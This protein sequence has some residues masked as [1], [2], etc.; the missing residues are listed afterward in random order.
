MY[1]EL[2]ALFL[3][4]M[5]YFSCSPL[6]YLLVYIS[7]LLLYWV[8]K[9]SLLRLCKAPPI[10]SHSIHN[11]AMQ[12]ILVGLMM[13]SIV[14]PLYYGNVDKSNPKTCLECWKIY[15]YYTLNFLIILFFLTCRYQI[16]CLYY[17]FK[18]KIMSLS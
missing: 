13:N 5:L 3:F 12:I 10:Y 14:S 9:Y 11:M 1:A 2:L 17:F 15:W 7:L 4:C 8:A 6:I 16:V 18:N